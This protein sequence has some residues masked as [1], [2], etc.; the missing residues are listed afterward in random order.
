M[1]LKV[2]IEI[3]HHFEISGTAIKD[4]IL[5]GGDIPCQCSKEYREK[6]NQ[7]NEI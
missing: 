5:N 1:K 2:V 3:D 6:M 7:R 4:A